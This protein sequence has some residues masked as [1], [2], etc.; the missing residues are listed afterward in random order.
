MLRIIFTSI[1]RRPG[2]ISRFYRAQH[3]TSAAEFALIA[4]LLLATVI[5]AFET[6]IFLFAQQALQNA[7][8]AAGRLF[9]TGQGQNSGITQTQLTNTICP[10]IQPL[11]NCSSLIVN[12]QSYASFSSASASAPQ[13]TFNAQGQVTNSWSFDLGTPGQVMVVQLIYQWPVVGGP[14]GFSLANLGNGTAEIM[15]VSSFRVEPY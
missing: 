10:L 3:G 13:L 12:V 7:A 9:L 15:G 14:L 4:P 1:S 5:A 6:S 2:R 8:V 11:F